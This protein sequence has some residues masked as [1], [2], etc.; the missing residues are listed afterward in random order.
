M[1][2]AQDLYYFPTQDQ[3]VYKPEQVT[4][5]GALLGPRLMDGWEDGASGDGDSR[6]EHG[7]PSLLQRASSGSLSVM[8]LNCCASISPAGGAA[9]LTIEKVGG[10]K[11]ATSPSQQP[12][13]TVW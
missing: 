6:S 2:T 5:E 12:D 13:G 9:V 7:V 1:W 3:E 11:A 4:V 10:G 8:M